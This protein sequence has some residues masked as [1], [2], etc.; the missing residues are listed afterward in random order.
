[1]GAMPVMLKRCRLTSVVISSAPNCSVQEVPLPGQPESG[2]KPWLWRWAG[3]ATS[4][5]GPAERHR[6]KVLWGAVVDLSDLESGTRG[7]VLAPPVPAHS[8]TS[9]MRGVL[10]GEPAH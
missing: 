4:R 5:L 9:W 6:E 3:C 2:S 10:F 7:A 8:R 1:M